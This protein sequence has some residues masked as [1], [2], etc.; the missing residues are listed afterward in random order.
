VWSNLMLH[1][2]DDPLPAFR[3]LHRVLEVGGLLMFAALGPDTLKELRAA[4]S[5]RKFHDMHDLGDMLVA[6]GFADPVMDMEVIRFNYSSPR[7]FLADQRHL[8]VRNA[9]LG[10]LPWQQWR[11]VFAA[12]GVAG[13]F[14][15]SFEIVFG[16]AWKAAPK[17]AA[18]GRAVIQFHPSRN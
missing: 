2:L 17:H 6:A 13:Q 11:R 14:P 3:E 8:G 9:L 4:G 16:H 15:V 10:Q 12:A 7:R 5:V 1:W 18:D